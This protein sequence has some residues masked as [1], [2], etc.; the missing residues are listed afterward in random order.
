MRKDWHEKAWD[1]YLYWQTQD[2]KT[3]KRIN[4]LIKDIERGGQGI[5]QPELLKG[6]LSGWA[7]VR[8][9]HVNRLVYRLQ[10]GVLQ[11]LSARGHYST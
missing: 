5:G 3:L 4:S 7:S 9:D 2:K 6:K 10:D 8:I 1:D 11:I